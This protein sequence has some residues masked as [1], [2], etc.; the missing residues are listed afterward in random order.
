MG[1]GVKR[2]AEAEKGREKERVEKW[3]LAMATWREEGRELG[4]RGQEA[5]ERQEYNRVRMTF[6]S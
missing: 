1:R 2:V 5:R 6:C 4:V 3:G